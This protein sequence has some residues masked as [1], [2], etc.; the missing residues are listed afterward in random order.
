[1]G[2]DGCKSGTEFS[3]R[4][5]PPSQD[6]LEGDYSDGVLSRN[7][8]N[9]GFNCCP[10][11][12]LAQFTISGDSICIQEAEAEAGCSCLCLFD[13]ELSV[14]NLSPGSY[15]IVVDEPYVGLGDEQLSATVTL[16]DGVSGAFCVERDDYP[17][18]LD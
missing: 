9:A 8:I 2:Y 11:G 17:W 4:A 13:L 18:R 6:C 16:S 3:T 14:S 15:A 7:H 12:L 5:R 1:M 10:G